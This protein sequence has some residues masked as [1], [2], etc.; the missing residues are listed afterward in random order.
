MPLFD[1]GSLF[2]DHVVFITNLVY[3]N[4]ALSNAEPGLLFPLYVVSKLL[5]RGPEDWDSPTAKWPPPMK[6]NSRPD[7]LSYLDLVHYVPYQ[8]AW[9]NG[10]AVAFF[11]LNI[12]FFITNCA[13]ACI[14]FKSRPG[15]LTHSFT[16]QTESLFI[17]SAVVSFAII[18]INICQFGVP[19][20]G[21]WLLRIMQIL[22]W[23]YIALS[24]LASA[25]IYLILWS[26]LI[27]PIHT[28]TP[29]WVFPAYP[30]L[31]TA[32]FASNLIQAAVQTNQQVVTLNRTAIALCAVATQGAGCLIAFMISA[33]FIYRL[34]T[35]KLP[36]DFQR[37]GV[38]SSADAPKNL[39]I[40]TPEQSV[41]TI[42]PKSSH[43][44]DDF[45]QGFLDPSFDPAAYLNATL[46]PLQHGSHHLSRSNG[47]AV[48]LADLSNEAQ[49]LLSQLNIHT[50]RL[51]GTLTQL[52][53]DILRSGSR[54][55]Y[56][57]ELLRGE[58]LSLAETMNETLQE[59]I[60]K[61]A[62][63]DVNQVV[64]EPAPKATDGQGRRESVG[65]NKTDEGTVTEGQ[66][67]MS[68]PPYINQL[69]T[70]TVV[71]SR[72]DTVI[73]TFGDAMEFVFPPSELSVSSSFL[74]VS[75]PDPGAEQHSTEE[76]GQQVLQ[77]LRDEISQLLTKL[78]DPVKGIEKAAQRIEE[79][80]ELNKV[81]KGTA[82]E[83]GRTKFIESLAKMVEDRHR[84]LMREVDQASRRDLNDGRA[85]KGSVHADAAENKTY[86]GGWAYQG[87]LHASCEAPE[88]EIL[89]G[90]EGHLAKKRMLTLWKIER[91]V[92]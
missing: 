75:A 3:M 41:A 19:H 60:K 6:W 50:T 9:L 69:R 66:A 72:L 27:F 73:K 48:P 4:I 84:D 33:A 80:K 52:T 18:S 14:R 82:E 17:P 64:K 37:P 89:G 35:Q 11:L 54:L 24:V 90:S 81:W 68:E 30:L 67:A 2:L 45:L 28:M 7:R 36:R 91:K 83:K 1:L 13:L 26:T 39:P 63:S 70:L 59:D 58:T 10:I 62:P 43:A 79:L 25:T 12:M 55:A 15:A 21:P 86:L 76:K 42:Q 34:M 49:T 56:E 78:E 88:P 85:R 51:S 31:L 38:N 20:V 22:F 23:F 44:A 87:A 57:V 53:D 32:P 5:A 74:S 71:R 92:R 61:F 47:Q 16:D 40:H 8:V 77:G 46:P 65:A 29:T